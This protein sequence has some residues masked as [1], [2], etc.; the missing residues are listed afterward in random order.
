MVAFIIQ[1]D[2]STVQLHTA[3]KT[4][5]DKQVNIE[6]HLAAKETDISTRSSKMIV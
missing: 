6:D 3:D 4:A 1:T 2:K 5:R